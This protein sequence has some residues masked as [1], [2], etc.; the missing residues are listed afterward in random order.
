MAK[1]NLGNQRIRY[2]ESPG[3]LTAIHEKRS[4]W[5][6]WKPTGIREHIDMK[7]AE[8]AMREVDKRTG[9]TAGYAGG[10][11]DTAGFGDRLKK[12]GKKLAKNKVTKVIIK[13][14]TAPLK[15]VHKVTH[16]KNSP[17]RKLEM[18][19]QGAV[20]KALP[21]TKPFIDFHNKVGSKLT[22]ATLAKVGIAPKEKGAVKGAARAAFNAAKEQGAKQAGID[23]KALK[24]SIAE[25]KR[26]LMAKEIV[27][28][29]KSLPPAKRK[30]AQKALV[31]RAKQ[32]VVQAPSGTTYRFNM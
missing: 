9:N 10:Y 15:A 6:G 1:K 8:A 25:E 3:T 32:F 14:H 20:T 30:A 23:P 22:N 7:R 17:I 29:T 24:R 13:A 18:K 5:G 4:F 26:K 27:K 2:V 19:I 28:A 16:G 11:D 31:T 21:F 12:F